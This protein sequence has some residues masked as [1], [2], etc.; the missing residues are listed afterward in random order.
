MGIGSNYIYIA[1]APCGIVKIGRSWS[2]SARV[3]GLRCFGRQLTLVTS[4][5]VGAHCTTVTFESQIHDLLKDSRTEACGLAAREWYLPTDDVDGL[6]IS[7]ASI[8]ASMGP[9]IGRRPPDRNRFDAICEYRRTQRGWRGS[10]RSFDATARL[11]G[12]DVE[13]IH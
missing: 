11:A 6:A 13:A 7:W 4:V 10:V 9:V 8:K 3:H 5:R 1:Q 12:L 2:P